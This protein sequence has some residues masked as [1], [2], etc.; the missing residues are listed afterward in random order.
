MYLTF[1]NIKGSFRYYEQKY[2]NRNLSL[3]NFRYRN[4][5][6]FF[7]IDE[8]KQTWSASKSIPTNKDDNN[9]GINLGC[10]P[11]LASAQ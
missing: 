6:I 11:Y 10:L 9:C 2:L 1:I 3:F 4:V 5:P 8:K 7:S